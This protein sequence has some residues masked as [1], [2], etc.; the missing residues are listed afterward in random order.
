MVS[1]FMLYTFIPVFVTMAHFQGQW[2][3]A[4]QNNFSCFECE[5][6]E[7]MPLLFLFFKDRLISCTIDHDCVSLLSLKGKQLSSKR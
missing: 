6:T 2:K 5:S 7:C 4:K 1:S 3:F